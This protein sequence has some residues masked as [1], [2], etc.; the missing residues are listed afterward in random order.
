[1]IGYNHGMTCGIIWY[2]FPGCGGLDG[3]SD[4]V[5][6][7]MVE[8]GVGRRVERNVRD[9]TTTTQQMDRINIGHDA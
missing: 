7:G 1:M 6:C 5:G 2:T 4:P 9:L 8:M 3:V